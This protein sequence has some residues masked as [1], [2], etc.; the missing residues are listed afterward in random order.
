VS[1]GP[2]VSADAAAVHLDQ[3][4]A[5]LLWFSLRYGI[6][7]SYSKSLGNVK[8]LDAPQP[9]SGSGLIA[10]VAGVV[11]WAA[12]DGDYEADKALIRPEHKRLTRWETG[13]PSLAVGISV[14]NFFKSVN[15]ALSFGHLRGVI[16]NDKLKLAIELF[17]AYRFELS[18]NAQLITLVTALESLLPDMEVPACSKAV[19]A[20]SKDLVKASRDQHPK[21]STEWRAINHLLSRIGSLKTEAIGTALRHHVSSVLLRHPDFGDSGEVSIKLREVYSVRSTLLHEG[22][23]AEQEVGMCLSFLR[24]FVPRLLAVLYEEAADSVKT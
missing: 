14:E 12:I 11:D 24:K 2:F 20:Q 19:L 9:V 15:Q 16:D 21:D 23:S 8:L 1:S 3:L 10:Q 4:R 22:R 6:G 7:V 18:N 5:S 17:A 13:H